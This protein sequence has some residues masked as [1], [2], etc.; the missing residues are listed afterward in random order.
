MDYTMHVKGLGFFCFSRQVH[1]FQDPS[2]SSPTK[3]APLHGD[4]FRRPTLAR[5]RTLQR[6]R[7][8]S[9]LSEAWHTCLVPGDTDTAQA[10]QGLWD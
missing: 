6:R 7:A 1:G 8:A 5:G 2:E 10:I 3:S 4:T 9:R